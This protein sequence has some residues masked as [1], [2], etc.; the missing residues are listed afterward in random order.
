[1]ETNGSISA[2]E[3]SAALASAR[4]SRTRVAFGGY[5]V[6]YWLATGAALGALPYTMTLPTWWDMA[7]TVVIA[8][9]LV[10]VARA[11]SRIRGVCEGWVRKTM[12]FRDSL[13]LYG[14]AAVL[15]LANAIVSKFVPWSPIGAAVLIFL[16][17]AGTGLTLGARA[18]RR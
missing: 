1:M 16:A 3:A 4:Q 12:T 10:L 11:A 9:T 7:A 6:W 15:I 2:D 13:V 14:P 5:P 18:D 17:F 8:A